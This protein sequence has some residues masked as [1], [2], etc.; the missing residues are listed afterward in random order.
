MEPPLTAGPTDRSRS[1]HLA[2]RHTAQLIKNLYRWEENHHGTHSAVGIDLDDDRDDVDR[3][4]VSLPILAKPLLLPMLLLP[5]SLLCAADSLRM[6]R[7]P[8]D[9]GSARG[10]GHSA[11]RVEFR[12][13]AV[14]ASRDCQANI[15]ARA[16][17]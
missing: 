17:C 12:H 1:S 10:S 14:G 11:A 15:A 9:S 6:W 3:H 16:S 4:G 13:C 5:S 8:S 7:G 2:A